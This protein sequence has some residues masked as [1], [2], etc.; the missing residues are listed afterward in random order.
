M[1]DFPP[2]RRLY[3]I[4]YTYTYR[5][6]AASTSDEGN[7]I[8]FIAADKLLY[9]FSPLAKTTEVSEIENNAQTDFNKNIFRLHAERETNIQ[10][11]GIYSSSFFVIRVASE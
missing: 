4:I 8:E 2:S 10:S 11:D 5:N 3:N 1:R 9:C 7:S 6:I